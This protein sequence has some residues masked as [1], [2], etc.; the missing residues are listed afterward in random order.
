MQDVHIFGPYS[1]NSKTKINVKICKS[2]KNIFCHKDDS[3]VNE[4][5]LKPAANNTR[6]SIS[7]VN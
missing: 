4:Q 7:L 3:K 2:A 6:V 5:A 1:Q